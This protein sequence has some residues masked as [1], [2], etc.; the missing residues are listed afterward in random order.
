MIKIEE[1]SITDVVDK[2]LQDLLFDEEGN[3]KYLTTKLDNYSLNYN[4]NKEIENI[5]IKKIKY[6]IEEYIVYSFA[7]NEFLSAGIIVINSQTGDT[8]FYYSIVFGQKIFDSVLASKNAGYIKELI[9]E[10]IKILEKIK[11]ML[12]WN[13]NQ[14]FKYFGYFEDIHLAASVHVS[15]Y[16]HGTKLQNG[17]RM[18]YIALNSILALTGFKTEVPPELSQIIQNHTYLIESRM[19]LKMLSTDQEDL[20]KEICNYYIVELLSFYKFQFSEN[21]YKLNLPIL[22][23]Q[24]RKEIENSLE[25]H[26]ILERQ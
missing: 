12:I 9:N 5:F 25:Y 2:T 7:S 15:N 3:F 20:R 26:N 6:E 14:S 18:F 8:V 4:I 22:I 13:Y 10:N 11:P 19:L 1:S 24:L 16:K 21:F 23:P 17:M